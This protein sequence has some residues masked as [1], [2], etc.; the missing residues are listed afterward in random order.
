MD[1]FLMAQKNRS[2]KRSEKETRKLAAEGYSP[3][4]YKDAQ[5]YLLDMRKR[6]SV[7]IEADS[8]NRDAALEDSLFVAGEQWDPQIKARRIA[9][10]KPIMT[11]NRLPAMVG[12]IVGNR[13]MNE[14]VIKVTPDVGG[15][16]AVAQLRQGL[17]RSIE[18]VS[19]ADRAYNRAFQNAVI[20]GIGNFGVNVEYAFDDVFERDIRIYEIPNPLAV[21]WDASSVE[22]TGADAQECFVIEEIDKEDFDKAYGDATTGDLEYDS[23][24]SQ[25]ING[26][27]YEEG[28]IRVVHHWHM[29]YEERT[30]WLME[31]GDVVDVTDVRGQ[32]LQ[33]LLQ[34]VAID[35]DTGG[36]YMRK[37]LRSKAVCHICTGTTILEGPIELPLKRLPVFRVPGWEIDT[38]YDRQRFGVVRFAK[39]PQ[40][41]HNYWR[42]VIVEKLMLTPKAPWVASKEAVEGYEKEWRNAHLSNDTLLIYNGDAAAAP[43]RTE[44][45]QIEAALIQE[46]SMASQDMKD[47]TNLHEAMMGMTSNEVS[48]KAILARQKMG[49][50]G[51]II[52]LDNLNMAIEECGRCI[53]DLIPIVYDT[54]R[55]I[56]V[57]DIDDLGS[58]EEKLVAINSI[59][60]GYPDITEGKYSVTVHTGPSQVTRRLEAA[61]GMLNMVN[62][63]PDFMRVAA[64]EIVR[65]QDWPGAEKIAKR[66]EKQ[67]GI[68]DPKDMTEEEK[69]QAMAQ[70]Q[71]LARQQQ[72][73]DAAFQADLM[74]KQAKTAE[75]MA[76]AE[77]AKAEIRKM[78][79]DTI[80]ELRRV[81]NEEERLELDA[82]EVAAKIESLDI[83][84]GAT[85]IEIARR[86]MEMETTPPAG[87]KM[88][89]GETN[90]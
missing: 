31:D 50:V 66:L 32:E 70:Q 83:N 49:E 52:F 86:I 22:P 45:A 72:M 7:D 16:R 1:G 73:Q 18:K 6:F 71:Q 59:D 2:S 39:D 38:A 10:N 56:K 19:K 60:D 5:S 77:K 74:E 20:C 76:R 12:Q 54:K 41:M 29:E 68:A 35:E 79:M 90:V 48:G 23:G 64:G 28:K 3:K 80:I 51:S 17:I 8:A 87:L 69:K 67:L 44:P 85:V 34:E 89:T 81:D 42:S 15:N 78:V 4:G 88:P 26:G 21:V 62:A 53:N 30:L 57:V 58:E 40:R 36:P 75:A 82:V 84:D 47:V 14:T 46:A 27:W 24:I 25:Q 63:M 37:T 11:I 61:E 13:R 33:E 65:A 55:I 9:E 43:R